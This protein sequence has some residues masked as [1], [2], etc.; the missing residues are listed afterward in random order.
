MFFR[1]SKFHKPFLKSVTRNIS[2]K[3]SWNSPSSFR[4]DNFTWYKC[5][6]P[7]LTS[8][9]TGEEVKK[10][11]KSIQCKKSP[12][13]PPPPLPPQPCFSMDQ[14]FTDIF[15]EEKNYYYSEII[16]KSDHRF[17]R[18]IFTNFLWNSI[19]LPWQPEFIWNQILWTIFEEV[20]LIAN[21]E[22]FALRWA[23]KGHQRN[24]SVKSFQNLTR[25]IRGEEFWSICKSILCKK[26]PPPS[27]GGHVF[28]RIKVSRI[29][30]EKGHPG[31]NPVKLFQNLTSGFRGEEFWRI[32]LKY[33]SCKK[34]AHTA[35]MFFD[36][37]KFREQFLKRSHKEQ[38]CEII[39]NSDQVFQRRRF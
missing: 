26:P 9:F 12:L 31:N 38:S 16:L 33:K 11:P 7:N 14:N 36:G 25:S 23:K 5:S 4:E 29:K 24:N 2:T 19:W 8:R 39:P 32:S 28:Q 6:E 22:H 15:W 10:F 30:F 27:P 3:F 21:L 35:A 1:D 20:I 13:P 17:Q 37:S 18:R 34:P